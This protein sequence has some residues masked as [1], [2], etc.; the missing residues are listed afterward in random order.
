MSRNLP[1]RERIL[2]RPTQVPGKAETY[3]NKVFRGFAHVDNPLPSCTLSAVGKLT[4]VVAMLTLAVWGLASMHCQLEGMPGFDF[5]RTCCFVDSAPSPSQDCEEDECVVES[6][7]YRAEEQ[8]VSVPQPL[9]LFALLSSVIEVPLPEPQ[10]VVASESPPEL[11]KVWQFSH[12]TAL[13]P[14]APSIAS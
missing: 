10:I 12:R 8:T 5:L 4:K 11:S 14:R 3:E 7:D 9:L 13:P 6:G 2:L 1:A